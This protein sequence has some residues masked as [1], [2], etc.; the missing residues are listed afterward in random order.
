MDDYTCI[1]LCPNCGHHCA[2]GRWSL[3]RAH[4][5]DLSIR[6]FGCCRRGA[7]VH[8]FFISTRPISDVING[9]LIY[10][11]GCELYLFLITLCFASI[12]ANILARL[13]S[14]P[15]LIAELNDRYSGATMSSLRVQRIQQSNLAR[16]KNRILSLTTK[17]RIVVIIAS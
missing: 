16:K 13:K 2:L 10:F 14:G 9:L 8:C 15:A 1:G 6:D 3:F 7:I 12:S 11:F 5:G 4:G 17:G